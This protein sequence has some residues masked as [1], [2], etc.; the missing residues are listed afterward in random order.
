MKQNKLTFKHLPNI[1]L[2]KYFLTMR[3]EIF[4]FTGDPNLQNILIKKQVLSYNFADFLQ[5]SLRFF[6]LIDGS[7][8]AKTVNKIN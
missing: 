3:H 2:H 6:T 5:G 4:K 8:Q 7:L 1:T